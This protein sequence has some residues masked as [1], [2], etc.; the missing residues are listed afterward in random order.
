[1]KKLRLWLL[2]SFEESLAAE[3]G[4]L[5]ESLVS[6]RRLL[7]VKHRQLRQLRVRIAQLTPADQLV[8][9]MLDR[10]EQRAFPLASRQRNVYR[11]R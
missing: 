11:W 7:V 5:E 8:Q 2:K 10:R 9:E 6:T 1:M 4:D 3:V